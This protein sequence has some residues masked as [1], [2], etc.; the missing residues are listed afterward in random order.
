M[1]KMSR[2]NAILEVVE[3]ESILNQ[4]QLRKVLG[5]V[6]FVVTQATLSRDIHELGLVKTAEGYAVNQGDPQNEPALP[7][8]LG[9]VGE[10]VTEVRGA[11]NLL[12]I[13]T[14]PES[15]QPVAA[16]IDAEGW[17]EIVGT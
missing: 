7:P 3:R 1:S 6:G 15:A 13:K 10:F 12:V 5:R 11:Q 2:Q 9:L 4:D 16:A 14:A 8:A 17:N